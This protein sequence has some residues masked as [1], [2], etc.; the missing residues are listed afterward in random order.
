LISILTCIN[1]IANDTGA[2]IR[3]NKPYPAVW[4][5]ASTFG[6]KTVNRE[7]KKSLSKSA[8]FPMINYEMNQVDK[9]R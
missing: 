7:C 1:P 8:S 9:T 6:G 5:L 2:K 3:D 4:V